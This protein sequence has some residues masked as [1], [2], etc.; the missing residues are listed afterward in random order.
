MPMWSANL[1]EGAAT[2]CNIMANATVLKVMC[3]NSDAPVPKLALGLQILA[4]M[5]WIA[6][7]TS[8]RDMYL[9]STA[10]TSLAMQSISLYMRNKKKR[11]AKRSLI[12]PDRSLDGTLPQM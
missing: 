8:H 2:F 9:A 1:T 6:F 7:A 11:E 10:C 4:N 5:L 3:I 12:K